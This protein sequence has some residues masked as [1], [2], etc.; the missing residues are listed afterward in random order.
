MLTQ[1]QSIIDCNKV[2]PQS[3]II[4]ESGQHF[5]K[6]G[7]NHVRV[8]NNDKESKQHLYYRFFV[9][10]IYVIFFIH[11]LISLSVPNDKYRDVFMYNGDWA[12]NYPEVRYHMNI[13]MLFC[14]IIA[15]LSTILH[16]TNDN[17]SWFKPFEM[18][19]GLVTPA[20]IGLT[21]SEDVEKLLKRS[22][23]Y[24]EIAEITTYFLVPTTTI[25]MN[26]V[27]ASNYGLY[28]FLLFGIPWGFINTIGS[29]LLCANI[30]Y[31]VCYFYIICEY[32]RMKLVK[33]YEKIQKVILIN[34]SKLRN[35]LKLIKILDRIYSEVEQYNRF[36]CKCLLLFYVCFLSLICTTLY[37]LAFGDLELLLKITIGYIAVM[38][39]LVLVS[40]VTPGIRF[41]RE[42][43]KSY[44][45]FI[46]LFVSTDKSAKALT[47]LKV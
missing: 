19:S 7:L 40:F 17:I 36:W 25:I 42:V 9:I 31:Q 23:L 22:K 8:G 32:L 24:L 15:I 37:S 27:M 16:V 45:L 6:I 33:I 10:I 13:T 29:H 44:L 18:M 11:S 47:K 41:S 12:Y 26:V 5:Y 4:P 3:Y 21:D 43:N 35:S 38:N 39:I 1:I 14:S 30:C 46:K 28:I 20:S 2:L 34:R